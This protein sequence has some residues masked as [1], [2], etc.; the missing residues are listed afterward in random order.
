[1]IN[2]PVSNPAALPAIESSKASV[3]NCRTRRRGVA[4][5]APRTAISRLRLSDR[6]SS[7]LATFTQAI[8]RSNPA[9]PSSVSKIGRTCPSISS[10][11]GWTVAP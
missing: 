6:T 8:S 2:A 3:M 1:M 10:E 5:S 7:R 11:S 4:P 9:P